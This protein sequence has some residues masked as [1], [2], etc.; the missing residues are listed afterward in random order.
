MNK[1][2]VGKIMFGA[3][4]LPWAMRVPLIKSLGALI[5]AG[6]I[7]VTA[8]AQLQ[9]TTPGYIGWIT[10]ILCW[11]L[12]ALYAVVCHRSVLLGSASV[13]EYGLARISERELHFVWGFIKISLLT[14]LTV[15]VVFLI[16]Q[17][18]ILIVGWLNTG[19]G[20]STGAVAYFP[21]IAYLTQL[22]ML[23]R[24]GLILPAI[25]IDKS[26]TLKWAWQVSRGNTLR[27]ML[28]LGVLPWLVQLPS[29]LFPEDMGVGGHAV[30]YLMWWLLLPIEITILSLSYKELANPA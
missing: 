19:R 25:A 20:D 24:L 1:L 22:Y 15:M 12:Y 8:R 26:P 18:P 27:L 4:Y 5:I 11:M 13:P 2:P 9:D 28:V 16:M 7:L 17:L 30:Y 29:Y 6:T 3:F 14:I 10:M 21:F 23:A